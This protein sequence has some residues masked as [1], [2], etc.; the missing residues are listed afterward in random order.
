MANNQQTN[1]LHKLKYK[2]YRKMY[3]ED[4]IYEED[5]IDFVLDFKALV[6]SICNR[7]PDGLI[8]TISVLAVIL[9]VLIILNNTV[10]DDVVRSGLEIFL[11]ILADFLSLPV[12]F[13]TFIFSL[14]SYNHMI[15]NENKYICNIITKDRITKN[16]SSTKPKSASNMVNE[17]KEYL[18]K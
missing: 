14:F 3:S 7:H 2:E 12:V 15:M 1:H 17:D 16:F 5:K 11:N 6:S 8:I 18:A 9:T 13:L 10:F 4:V